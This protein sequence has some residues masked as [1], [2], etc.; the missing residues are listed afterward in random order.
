MARLAAVVGSLALGGA[1][2]D[3]NLQRAASLSTSSRIS[4]SPSASA[5]A[6]HGRR[7]IYVFLCSSPLDPAFRAA[8]S[9]GIGSLR[10]PTTLGR[11]GATASV[12]T[13][14]GPA[15]V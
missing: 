10:Q 14:P 1:S 7:G 9:D 11:A 2:G 4:T 6:D 12:R 13:R 15:K 5:S 3:E 8:S